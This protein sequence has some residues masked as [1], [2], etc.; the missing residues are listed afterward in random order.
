MFELTLQELVV[1]NVALENGVHEAGW[2]AVHFAN[3]EAAT[4]ALE[5]Y[6]LNLLPCHVLHLFSWHK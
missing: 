5:R 4:I 1:A 2:V 6:K 3:E